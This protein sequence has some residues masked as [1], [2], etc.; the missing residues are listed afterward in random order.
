[1]LLYARGHLWLAAGKPS[2]A[3]ADFQALWR[4]DELSGQHTPRFRRLRPRRSRIYSSKSMTPLAPAAPRVS[5]RRGS[6]ARRPGSPTRCGRQDLSRA[7]RRASS[8][9]ARQSRP[10]SIRQRATSTPGPKPSSAPRYVAPVSAATRARHCAKPSTRRPLRRIAACARAT[11]SSRPAR[12]RG[13]QRCADATADA[14]R[15]PRRAL[16]AEGI[17]PRDRASHLRHRPHR[18]G[19]PH[20]CVHEARHQLPRTA[21]LNTRGHHR[22]NEIRRLSHVG[23]G[24]STETRMRAPR[25]H[26]DRECTRTRPR[27]P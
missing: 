18:R 9:C 3:L 13:A 4:R 5:S 8:S 7:E 23:R 19:S 2:A 24:D 15:T 12:A 6:G 22:L 21:P 10:S 14:E 26:A 25:R 11:S 27:A 17:E 16:A 20:Q 1:M